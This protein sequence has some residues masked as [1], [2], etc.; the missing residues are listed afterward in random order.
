MAASAP[1]RSAMQ[2]AATL[3]SRLG[4]IP[5][6]PAAAPAKEQIASA[7]SKALS[8]QAVTTSCAVYPP[9]LTKSSR[10]PAKMLAA[11]TMQLQ[12]DLL[13]SVLSNR[14]TSRAGPTHL[15]LQSQL[16]ATSTSPLPTPAHLDQLLFTTS[17]MSL[18]AQVTTT[19]PSPLQL[20]R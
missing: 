16:Q 18:S 1:T 12:P 7:T 14:L 2:A 9:P 6:N 10:S 15:S 17:R 3:M 4:P 19:P 20:A 13:V 5:T 11:S 8:V